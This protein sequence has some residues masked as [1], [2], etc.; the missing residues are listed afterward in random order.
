MIGKVDGV[1]E[2][3]ERSLGSARWSKKCCQAPMVSNVEVTSIRALRP[4]AGQHQYL[5]NSTN[6]KG[7]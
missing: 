7:N 3:E 2:A 6:C 4:L 5:N 1:H